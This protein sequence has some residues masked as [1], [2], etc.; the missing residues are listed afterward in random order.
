[1]F[2]HTT[3]PGP[4]VAATPSISCIFLLLLSKAF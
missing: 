1:M 2:K 4:T 3:K